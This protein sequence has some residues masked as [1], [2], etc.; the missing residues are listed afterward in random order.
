MDATREQVLRS[1]FFLQ[2]ECFSLATELKAC[3]EEERKALIH[4]DT[5]L[6]VQTNARKENLSR[7]LAFKRKQMWSLVNAH[8]GIENT[9][10]LE[11]FLQEPWM[12][13]WM[14]KKNNWLKVWNETTRVC[15][16]NQMFLRHSL[17]NLG[18]LVDHLKRLFGDQPLYTA[19]GSKA[20]SNQQGKVVEKSF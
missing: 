20:D 2:D 5:Q 7:T 13:Q 6:V 12:S 3:L 1:L 17:R 16:T 19:K 9:E 10:G 8:F 11:Q 15:E 4:L 14:E 18:V